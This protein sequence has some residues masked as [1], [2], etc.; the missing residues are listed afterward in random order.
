MALN[1]PVVALFGPTGSQT[2]GSI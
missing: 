2:V 1:K